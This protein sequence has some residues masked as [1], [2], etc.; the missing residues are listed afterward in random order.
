MKTEYGIYWYLFLKNNWKKKK[1][2]NRKKEKKE[3]KEW[4]NEKKENGYL[5][6]NIH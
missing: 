1:K 5:T 4:K 6:K 2:R 3:R